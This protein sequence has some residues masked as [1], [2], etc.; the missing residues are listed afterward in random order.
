MI[1]ITA[2]QTIKEDMIETY[3]KLAEE[4]VTLSR[5]EE[6]CVFYYSSRSMEEKNVF[7]FVEN[8]KDQDAIDAHGKTEHFTRIVPQF[9]ELFAAEEIV[10]KYEVVK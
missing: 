5:Q 6:G 8:W 10:T 1:I 2:K 9:A 4:L 7:M 3:Q